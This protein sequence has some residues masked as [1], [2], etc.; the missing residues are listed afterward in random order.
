MLP[1][2]NPDSALLIATGSIS[3]GNIQLVPMVGNAGNCVAG[4][5]PSVTG[6]SECNVIINARDGA[7]VTI[8]GNVFFRGDVVI[9]GV[10]SGRGAI[11]S[12]R[13]IY[14][15][16]SL[17]NQ[18]PAP[19]F[20]GQQSYNQEMDAVSTNAAA[21]AAEMTSYDELKLFATNNIVIG[22]PFA[23]NE[24]GQ[25]G[26]GIVGTD[27]NYALEIIFA[28]YGAMYRDPATGYNLD[29]ASTDSSGNPCFVN[30]WGSSSQCIANA[31]QEPFYQ[32]SL[33]S[34]VSDAQY[35]ND[36]MGIPY[37]AAF[38]NN[39]YPMNPSGG[40]MVPW[41][42]PAAFIAATENTAE[43]TRASAIGANN[44]RVRQK[45]FTFPFFTAQPGTSPYNTAN[46]ATGANQ[47]AMMEPYTHM[48]LASVTALDV[49][50]GTGQNTLAIRAAQFIDQCIGGFGP[51]SRATTESFQL[52]AFSFNPST[53]LSYA[54]IVNTSAGTM[55]D[56][57]GL[58]ASQ[59]CSVN[60]DGTP[61]PSNVTVDPRDVWAGDFSIHII[62]DLGS[63]PRLKVITPYWDP[64]LVRGRNRISLIQATLFANQFI[65]HAGDTVTDR[66]MTIDGGLIAHEV[67]GRFTNQ[68]GTDR[69]YY[70]PGYRA[71][72][73]MN[74]L[75]YSPSTALVVYEDPRFQFD[76]ELISVDYG[77]V[78]F[79]Y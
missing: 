8:S 27:F 24:N 39:F 23:E 7:P 59:S 36:Q 14:I 31:V 43:W 37:P 69:I 3:G 2:F 67:V 1:K 77:S 60:S 30:P 6:I 75:D 61:Y 10:V 28:N 13:N 11:Y 20:S 49:S 44:E 48:N 9:F 40:Q 29:L 65:F 35:F 52:C 19:H 66:R 21:I 42:S 56:D 12:G 63:Y 79:H 64:T 41:I 45:M 78:L 74:L 4:V 18:N 22:D 5:T 62:S 57:S 73:A 50:P 46:L 38:T 70:V 55:C 17:T 47:I 34:P 54:L 33:N 71:T 68:M 26:T 25:I 72:A 53:G 58:F 15:A 51:L 32:Y 16:D 76:T